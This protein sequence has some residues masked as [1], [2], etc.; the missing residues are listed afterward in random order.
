[1]TIKNKLKNRQKPQKLWT[2]LIKIYQA[3]KNKHKKSTKS[4]QR[5]QI[6]SRE[7]YDKNKIIFC[8]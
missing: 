4:E 2:K 7:I 1:M 3:K 6:N 5:I 8:I